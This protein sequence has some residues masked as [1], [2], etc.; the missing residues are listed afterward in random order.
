[1]NNKFNAHGNSMGVVVVEIAYRWYSYRK[2]GGNMTAKPRCYEGT[3]PYIFVSY[4]RKD[5]AT[6]YPIIQ[7][8]N[9]SGLRVWYDNGIAAS[10]IFWDVIAEH[11]Q[12]SHCV[13]AFLSHNYMKSRNCTDE[14][15][16]SLEIN[17]NV[18]PVYLEQT[19]I[20]PGLRLKLGA[21]Q[22]LYFHRYASLNTF[23]RDLLQEK[24][25]S[26]CLALDAQHKD[27][28][29]S[30]ESYYQQGEQLISGNGVPKNPEQAFK[31]FLL[32]A[33]AGHSGAQ[34]RLGVCYDRGEGV[35][36]NIT[37]AVIWY[38]KAVENGHPSAFNNLAFL[39]WKG[40][41]VRKDLHFAAE[42]FRKGAALGNPAAA[43]NLK[44]CLAELGESE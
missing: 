37:S 26:P 28:K 13:L 12:K 27:N 38:I 42:L 33:N 19:D 31:Y 1:M 36:R 3:E 18:L 39:Y 23:V 44:S 24:V 15:Y 9:D 14:L 29:L 40:I 17:P 35:Q 32:A 30:A 25:I 41:G 21:L 7:A 10:S 34:F 43:S 4:A 6:V 8:M 22:T 20:S 2:G 5:S 11:I 16:F